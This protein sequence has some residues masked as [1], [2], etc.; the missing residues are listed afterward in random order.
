VSV[1]NTIGWVESHPVGKKIFCRTIVE[2]YMKP[3]ETCKSKTLARIY[4]RGIV[5]SWAG[6][7]AHHINQPFNLLLLEIK[8]GLQHLLSYNAVVWPSVPI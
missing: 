2:V 4:F 1:L 3:Y 8:C 7:V 6:R 5:F